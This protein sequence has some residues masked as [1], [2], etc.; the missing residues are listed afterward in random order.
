MAVGDLKL[1]GLHEAH[2]HLLL[3]YKEE[4]GLVLLLPLISCVLLLATRSE[5]NRTSY[6]T[7][8]LSENMNI[9][10]GPR[11]ELQILLLFEMISEF[12]FRL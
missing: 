10:T 6:L 8:D 1:E 2:R 5:S 7:A 4:V 9:F 12:L 11:M 3:V